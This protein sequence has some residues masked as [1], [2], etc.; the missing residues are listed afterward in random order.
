MPT[1]HQHLITRVFQAHH[2]QVLIPNEPLFLNAQLFHGC[3][4]LLKGNC[5]RW[6]W[7]C[8]MVLGCM[9]L[10]GPRLGCTCQRQTDD[11]MAQNLNV[12]VINSG[13][14][15]LV[16]PSL[17]QQKAVTA[18]SSAWSILAA[19]QALKRASICSAH[20][21]PFVLPQPF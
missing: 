3:F 17:L 7:A 11:S 8:M 20:R 19:V 15:L 2:T 6:L 14:A 16:F 10:W 1:G 5:A 9:L 18:E 12:R 21:L 4:D 13:A